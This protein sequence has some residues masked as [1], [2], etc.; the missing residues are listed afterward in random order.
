VVAAGLVEAGDQMR[1]AGTGRAGA[2]REPPIE[3]GLPGSRERRAL[4]MA[5]ADPLD[6]TS[7]D[8]I[9]ERIQ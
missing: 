7:T 2:Y 8:R 6:A 9:G 5:Y 3:L 4:L 1:A